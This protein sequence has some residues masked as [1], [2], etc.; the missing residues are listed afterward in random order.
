M[1]AR[2]ILRARP[3]LIPVGTG[4]DTRDA[5]EAVGRVLSRPAKSEAGTGRDND[6]ILS[7]V[8]TCPDLVPTKVG[9]LKAAESLDVP[10]V[11]TCS[12]PKQQRA[13]RSE[14]LNREPQA[15]DSAK[16]R[17]DP[18]AELRVIAEDLLVGRR[19]LRWAAAEMHLS[20]EAVRRL[21][22]GRRL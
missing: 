1:S 19:G 3:L 17:F 11:P 4:R 12:D 10:T 14:E 22:A 7:N 16:R 15:G 8:P 9:T 2:N 5:Q 20:P 18:D 6:K 21:L 13:R